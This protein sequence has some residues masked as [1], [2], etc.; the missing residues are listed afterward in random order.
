MTTFQTELSGNRTSTDNGESRNERDRLA[1]THLTFQGTLN[2][3]NSNR[4]LCAHI[5]GSSP[6]VFTPLWL[7]QNKAYVAPASQIWV[8]TWVWLPIGGDAEV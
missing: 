3:Q 4:L 2:R 6:T 7:L 8:F 5:G 1:A